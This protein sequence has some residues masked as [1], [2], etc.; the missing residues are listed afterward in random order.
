MFACILF[1]VIIDDLPVLFTHKGL[2]VI[3]RTKKHAVY[4]FCFSKH[5]RITKWQQRDSNPQPLGLATWLSVR[6]QT[7]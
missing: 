2:N 1:V 5:K 6:L 3:L 7:K 4:S